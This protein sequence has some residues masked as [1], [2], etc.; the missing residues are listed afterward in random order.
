[1]KWLGG[2]FRLTPKLLP[3][4]PAHEVYV[5][6]FGG[7]GSVLLAKERSRV[8]IYNEIDPNP[9]NFF[10][11]LQDAKDF[12]EFRRLVDLT[13]YSRRE[14]CCFRSSFKSGL[15]DDPVSR[16]HQWYVLVRQSFGG[17]VGKS[18]GSTVTKSSRGMTEATSSYLASVTNLPKMAARLQGVRIENK[19]YREIMQDFDSPKTF[20]YCDPPYLPSTRIH[21]EYRFEMSE[22]QHEELIKFLLNLEGK[23]MLSGYKNEL[24]RR[25]EQAGWERRDFPQKLSLAGR[26][27]QHR[28]TN[29]N[30][31]ESIWMNYEIRSRSD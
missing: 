24:Y 25:L 8:E 12:K 14:Y 20:F 9:V 10:R 19:D 11:V 1:L 17:M 6:P 3:L 31:V 23:I 29:L 22:T 13:I 16:A 21:G 28:R 27:Y 30:R 7:A 2:K 18:W 26:T 4:I 5:E 15:T